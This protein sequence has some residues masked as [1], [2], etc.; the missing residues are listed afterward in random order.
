MTRR[1]C[2]ND[3]F[4]L[5]SRVRDS[6][7]MTRVRSSPQTLPPWCTR[8]GVPDNGNNLSYE[9]SPQVSSTGRTTSV[10]PY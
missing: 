9:T 4:L 1:R 2:P 6:K 7:S 10:G 8:T 5:N 3:R